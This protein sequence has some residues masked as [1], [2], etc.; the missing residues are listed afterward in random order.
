VGAGHPLGLTG[1]TGCDLLGDPP[2]DAHRAGRLGPGGILAPPGHDLRPRLLLRR[3]QGDEAADHVADRRVRGERDEHVVELPGGL[4]ERDAVAGQPGGR[5]DIRFQSRDHHLGAVRPSGALRGAL[6]LQ[7]PQPGRQI[8][9]RDLAGL[10]REPEVVGRRGHVGAVH[11]GAADVAAPDRH[12]AFGLQGPD[13]LPDRGV[14]EV[15]GSSSLSLASVMG[16][17]ARLAAVRVE[18]AF[19]LTHFTDCVK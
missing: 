4:G 3:P 10:Q 9:E 7:Q 5:L 13:G 6:R 18:V 19:S 16:S 15:S 8:S 17:G 12:Q 2:V 14:A 11:L 1:P